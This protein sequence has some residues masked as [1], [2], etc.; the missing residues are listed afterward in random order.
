MVIKWTHVKCVDHEIRDCDSTVIIIAAITCLLL[1]RFVT[2]FF[3]PSF[4]AP[5]F[6]PYKAHVH[7]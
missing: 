2:H 1:V 3:H 5:L 6:V 7:P 4:F